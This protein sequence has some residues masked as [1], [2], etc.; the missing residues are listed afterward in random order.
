MESCPVCNNSAKIIEANPLL[1]NITC[2]RCG[3][4]ALPKNVKYSFPTYDPNWS[5][6]LQEYI[7]M[8]QTADFVL[9]DSIVMGK[10]FSK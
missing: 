3:K 2:T 6:K 10:L 7:Q 5:K 1:E 8:H 9:I 4:F